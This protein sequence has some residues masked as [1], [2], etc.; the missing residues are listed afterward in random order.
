MKPSTMVSPLDINMVINE[1]ESS[2]QWN[3]MQIFP[4][5]KSLSFLHGLTSVQYFGTPVTSTGLP[6]GVVI[7]AVHPFAGPAD[8]FRIQILSLGENDG[9]G[10]G[11]QDSGAPTISIGNI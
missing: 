4:P 9:N 10:D 2:N 8:F 7:Q 1:E 6:R 5:L 3:T 11:G